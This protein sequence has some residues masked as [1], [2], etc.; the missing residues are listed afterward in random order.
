L[1]TLLSYWAGPWRLRT[2]V[3]P[4]AVLLFATAGVSPV[5]RAQTYYP[6]DEPGTISFGSFNFTMGTCAYQ[7]NNGASTSCAGDDLE[8][9]VT[10]TANSV[11]LTYVNSNDPGSPLLSQASANGCTCIQFGLTVSDTHGLSAAT[12]SDTGIGKSGSTLDNW[13]ETYGTT[14]KLAQAGITTTGEQS[15]SGIYSP[16]A[17]P[18]SLN[19]ELGLG[20][21]AAYQ[22]GVLSLNGASFTF[23][24]AP[25]PGSISVFLTGFGCLL[26]LRHRGRARAMASS[27]ERTKVSRRAL[28]IGST[29]RHDWSMRSHA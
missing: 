18:T 27:A 22:P 20:V 1:F 23:T 12:V 29:S 28:M 25:E 19:L 4:L 6:L 15:A 7:L 17:S 9:S 16:G 5:A 14:A 8:M 3:F 13:V 2:L 10:T 26:L 24:Q 11:T 21:N